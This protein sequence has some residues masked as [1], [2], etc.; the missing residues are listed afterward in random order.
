MKISNHSFGV[1][2]FLLILLT[3]CKQSKEVLPPDDLNLTKWINPFIGTGGHGHTYPGATVPFGMVQLSPDTRLTGWDGCSGYH[4]TDSIVYG[5]SHTHLSGT[6]IPDY[7]DLLIMPTTGDM[8]LNNGADGSP[9]YRSAFDKKN[10]M[11]EAGYYRTYLDD[12]GI[13]VELTSSKRVGF[14]RYT[15]TDDSKGRNLIIDLKHRDDLLA[16]KMEE[17]SPTRIEGYRVSK[18]WAQHQHFYFVIESNQP[19][20]LKKDQSDSVGVVRGYTIVGAGD[21]PLLLKVGISFTSIEGARANL[22]AE[23]TDW[24]FDQVRER[25]RMAWEEQMRKIVIDTSDEV[26]NRIFYTALYHTMIVPNLFQDVDGKYRG[27]DNKIHVSDNQDIYSVFSLWDTYRAAHPLYTLIEKKRTSD[28]INTF[29]TH[30]KDGGML[31]V[32]E[33]AANETNCMIGYH[34]VSVIA[35]AYLKGIKGFDAEYALEAMQNSANQDGFGLRSYRFFGYI[36]ADKESESVSKTLEYAYDDWCIARMAKSMKKNDVYSKFIRRAQY[37]KNLFDPNTGFMRAKANN[38]WWSPFYPEEV[39]SNYTEANA[40]QYSMYA[41]HD[42]SGLI[43]LHGS[44][45]NFEKHLDSMFSVSSKTSGREQADITGLIGQYAQGN[46]P[47]HH[48]AYLY[49]FVNK[50][51]KTQSLVSYIK[52]S[53]YHDNSDGLIGNEDCGQ[54]SAWYVFSALGFYPV[55]PGSNTYVIGSPSFKE[56][57]LFL[58]N[59]KTFKIIANNYSEKKFHIKSARLNGRNYNNSWISHE[60]IVGGG[61][62]EFEMTD[63][64]NQVWGTKDENV[65]QT[66]ITENLIMPIPAVDSATKVYQ[67]SQFVH[68]DHPYPDAN[69]YYTLDSTNPT[70]RSKKYVAPFKIDKSIQIRYFAEQANGDESMIVSSRFNKIPSGRKIFLNTAFAPQYSGGGD[71]AL[72]DQERGATDFRVG[73]WQGYEGKDLDVVVD[74]G[75]KMIINEVG[76]SCLQDENAWIFMPVRVEIYYSRDGW[77]FNALER[78]KTDVSP[79][80][81]GKIAR[82]FTTLKRIDARYIRIIARNMGTIPDWHLGAGGKPWIFA[83][84]IIINTER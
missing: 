64:V 21:Q 46:E 50:P 53:L 59:K 65:P 42:I 27:M 71:L 66:A 70:D 77:H 28:F 83:D 24:N 13:E 15:W 84:E 19:L 82:E 1:L 45:G 56:A 60:D 37:Y 75:K 35:D 38:I 47:S 34:S 41:P 30:Y 14:H 2:A 78:I 67:D 52:D 33:L 25:A 72:I 5:F 40:W 44:A 7:G 51:E 80:E 39:N 6:G 63:S 76:L 10:E 32:W 16:F 74:L 26:K 4:Y 43:K 62:L 49:N 48:V 54:M 73:G 36:P 79:K 3:S 9:G 29:L 58:E 61:V 22:N 11:A 81:K 68:L 20:S 69:I 17:K 57:T 18:A 12:Y 55:T 31:P 8:L 23:I